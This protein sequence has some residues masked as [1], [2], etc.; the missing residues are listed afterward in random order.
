LVIADASQIEARVLEWC[1]GQKDLIEKFKQFDA[2]EGKDVYCHMADDIVG[3]AVHKPRKDDPKDV[4]DR[5]DAARFKGKVAVLGGGYG[6][7]KNKF[8]DTYGLPIEEAETIVGVYRQKNDKIV[9][10]W[11]DVENAFK[12]MFKYGKPC[13]LPCGIRFD[14]TK[15]CDVILTL[16]N[17]RELKYHTVQVKPDDYGESI[18]VWNDQ[19]KTWVHIW[20]GYLTENIVQA[21]SRDILWDAIE[22]LEKQ[23]H[24]TA[25]HVHD[26]LIIV[27]PKG[28]GEKVLKLAEKALSTNPTW[29][30]E[31]PLAAEG[32]VSERYGSH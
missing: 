9:K 25:L 23:G 30:L 27:T 13:Q 8:A 3:F 28:T 19:E 26:E 10:F 24:H 5:M 12:Y 7:G 17:G 29:A 4:A 32:V 20:G 22:R 14:Q 11:T 1:A 15:D 18:R 21:I 16:P 6:M 2:G 31:C